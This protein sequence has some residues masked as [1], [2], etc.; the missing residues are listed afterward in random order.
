MED[1]GETMGEGIPELNWTWRAIYTD[2]QLDQFVLGL[3][4]QFKEIDQDRLVAFMLMREH[5]VIGVNLT[6]GKFYLNHI[7]LNIEPFV[8][9]PYKLIYF[10]RVRQSISQYGRELGIK[11]TVHHLGWQIE[12]SSDTHNHQRILSVKDT[13]V[14]EFSIFIK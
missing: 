13:S 10:R 7:D 2:G 3:E 9:G 6:D 12:G 1:K 4:H 14:G 11:E 8:A 5:S